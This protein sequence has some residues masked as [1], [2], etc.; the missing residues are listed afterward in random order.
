MEHKPLLQTIG[1]MGLMFLVGFGTGKSMPD[2]KVSNKTVQNDYST[3]KAKA[4]NAPEPAVKAEA[5]VTATTAPEATAV[6]ATA[7]DMSN[8]QVK[9]NISAKEKIYHVK[10]GSFYDRVKAEQCFNTEAEAKAAGFRKS[11]R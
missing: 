2:N 7:Q 8:C 4:E 6:V 10:G 9:G 1:L 5:T 3:I 11:S